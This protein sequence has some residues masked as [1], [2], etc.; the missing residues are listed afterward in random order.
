ME[1][2]HLRLISPLRWVGG[3][4][5]LASQI[6]TRIPASSERYVEPFLGGGSI[7]LEVL[8]RRLAKSY[9]V[10]DVNTHLINMWVCIK[11][12]LGELEMLLGIIKEFYDGAADKRD[13]YYGIRHIFNSLSLHLD[14]TS[15]EHAAFFMS[16]NKICFNALVRYN[17]HG[18]FNSAFGKREYIPIELDLLRNLNRAFNDNDVTFRC[19]DFSAAVGEYLPGDFFYFDPPYHPLG[20]RKMDDCTY[21]KDGFWDVD[22]RRL[23]SMCDRINETGGAFLL[24]NH[25]CVEI[26]EYF[27]GYSFVSLSC[28]KSFTG[29][30]ES[31]KD[32]G[33][34]LIGNRILPDL[35]QLEL[36]HGEPDEALS[37]L[38][39]ATRSVAGAADDELG[40]CEIVHEGVREGGDF[41]GG[42]SVDLG[43]ELGEIGHTGGEMLSPQVLGD[44]LAGLEAGGAVELSAGSGDALE[45]GSL[46][47]GAGDH[48]SART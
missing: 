42:R 19:G 31:R 39:G 22:E 4:R 17:R 29:H 45:T 23:R 27:A 43:G 8:S 37:S 25:D 9:I 38:D 16:L 13:A 18:H 15:P 11:D 10:S 47:D 44:D 32:T 1:D 33:E 12:R 48:L 6:M 3:K 20:T 26:R 35:D 46:E 5:A 24:S 21:S 7:F 28:Y 40:D 30:K 41:H 2:S 34:V 36:V 14:G